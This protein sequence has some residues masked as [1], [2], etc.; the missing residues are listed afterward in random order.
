MTF[1]LKNII[2][3]FSGPEEDVLGDYIREIANGGLTAYRRIIQHGNKQGQPLYA[4]VIDLVFTFARLAELLHLDVVEQRV[5]MLALSAHDI[6]KVSDRKDLRFADLASPEIIAQE[7]QRL[8]ADRFFPEWRTY[9]L[10]IVALIRAHSDHFHHSG[11]LLF[12]PVVQSQRYALGGQS[13]NSP[14][15]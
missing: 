4:H 8:G 10:D 5:M 9:L 2:L 3:K 11:E 13:K 6:N 14:T 7:L 12:A 1:D 15:S